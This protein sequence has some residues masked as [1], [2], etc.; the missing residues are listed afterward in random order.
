MDV[1]QAKG[2]HISGVN[3]VVRIVADKVIVECDQ[4]DKVIVDA[5]V[6][7]GKKREDIILAYAGEDEPKVADWLMSK[8]PVFFISHASED[9]AQ[10]QIYK[11]ILEEGFKKDLN[12]AIEVFVSTAP[13]AIRIG[14]EWFDTVVTKLD[15]SD[16]LIVLVTPNSIDRPWVWFE[17]GYFW[18]KRRDNKKFR[19][20]PMYQKGIQIPSPLNTLQGKIIGEEDQELFGQ[21]IDDMGFV[22]EDGNI[23]EPLEAKVVE[24]NNSGEKIEEIYESPYSHYSEAE[25]TELLDDYL[26]SC[27]RDYQMAIFQAN[28]IGEPWLVEERNYV[29][30]GSLI[31]YKSF[32]KQLNL[33]TGTAQKLLKTVAAK[34][35]LFPE[36]NSDHANT[37]RLHLVEKSENNQLNENSVSGDILF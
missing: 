25:L 30:N 24:I 18:K 19:I 17:V 23:R 36:P 3:L 32:D 15:K 35:N 28:E 26:H 11:N 8:K 22:D 34:N 13:S 6:Q 2:K 27:I 20:Y 4:N 16:A 31:D 9:K 29:C 5:L 10:A 12:T 7:A 1:A 21:L 14:R 33:P 37:I